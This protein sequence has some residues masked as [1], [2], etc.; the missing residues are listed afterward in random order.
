[1]ANVSSFSH[2]S[3]KPS[4]LSSL[5]S[6]S[7]PASDRGLRAAPFATFSNP[8]RRR[9]HVTRLS[10]SRLRE[11]RGAT[12]SRHVAA[13]ANPRDSRGNR[14]SADEDDEEEIS[15]WEGEEGQQKMDEIEELKAI[16]R[17]RKALEKELD[18]AEED[19]RRAAAAAA[20]AGGGEG[21]AA[22]AGGAAG[23]ATGIGEDGLTAEQRAEQKAARLRELLAKRA[24]EQAE[25]R[26]E[27]Q[28]LFA[29]GQQAY[30]RG[31]YDKSVAILEQALGNV[32]FTSKLGGEIQLWLAMSYDANGQRPECLALYRKL[33]NNHPMPAIRKQ[34]ADMRYIAEAPKLKLSPDEILKVP[35]LDKD[36]NSSGRT[37]SQMVRDRKP[38]KIRKLKGSGSRDY[39]DDLMSFKPPRWEKSPYFWVALTVWLT[40]VGVALMF[41][42]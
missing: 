1:M 41:Q 2:H 11:G 16:L 21:G 4:P 10:H 31:V 25:R 24:Q 27:A 13:Q 23:A 8:P 36:N 40:M 34:A 35:I 33:E 37:W 38:K 3:A 18:E 26:Q 19:M 29:F 20:T 14:E 7:I 5:Q 9:K 6:S 28:Q 22:A 32:E 42:D 15:F 12:G 30:G 17:E 39:M